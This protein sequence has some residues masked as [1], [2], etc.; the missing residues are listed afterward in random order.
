MA[1]VKFGAM[2][3]FKKLK[4]PRWAFLRLV[5]IIIGMGAAGWWLHY[6]LND[7]LGWL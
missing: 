4:D 7:V 2:T 3:F 6:L 5:L 1:I